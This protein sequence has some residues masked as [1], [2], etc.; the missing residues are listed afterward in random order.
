MVKDIEAADGE[1]TRRSSRC[2]TDAGEYECPHCH[3]S[4]V[5][6]DDDQYADDVI[7]EC[8]RQCETCGKWFQIVCESVEIYLASYP[9]AKD[10]EDQSA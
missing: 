4:Y 9:A 7:D 6:A 2:Y 8:A 3:E 1:Q 10:G 5:A